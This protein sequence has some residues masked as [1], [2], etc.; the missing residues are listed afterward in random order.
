MSLL[1]VVELLTYTRSC[2]NHPDA[3]GDEGEVVG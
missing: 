3:S 1:K 2:E